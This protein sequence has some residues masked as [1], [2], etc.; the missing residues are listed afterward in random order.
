M[1]KRLSNL[2]PFYK[3]KTLPY[4]KVYP[5]NLFK[6]QFYGYNIGCYGI[7]GA[8]I[9]KENIEIWSDCLFLSEKTTKNYTKYSGLIFG[10]QKAIQ[11]QIKTIYVEGDSL[12]IINQMNEI[13][14]CKC[15]KIINL[16]FMSSN[17]SKYF[18]NISFNYV[19]KVNNKCYDKSFVN[20]RWLLDALIITS[21]PSVK[22]IP[23]CEYISPVELATIKPAVEPCSDSTDCSNCIPFLF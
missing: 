18:D 2:Q 9:Y 17:L 3:N 13:S 23:Y 5:D 15:K 20:E 21:I 7:A 10:L 1:L 14:E 11:M 16:Y 8:T 4:A 19:S 6:L 12:K 22:L